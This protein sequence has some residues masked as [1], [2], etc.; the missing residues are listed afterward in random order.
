MGFPVPVGPTIS[1]AQRGCRPSSSTLR[2]ES[3]DNAPQLLIYL[4]LI[5]QYWHALRTSLSWRVRADRPASAF[6]YR[7]D[8]IFRR[9]P[10]PS[11]IPGVRLARLPPDFSGVRVLLKTRRGH[12]SSPS[13]LNLPPREFWRGADLLRYPRLFWG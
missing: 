8:G 10:E 3:P 13:P 9:E 5:W 4:M 11:G 6:R 1:V 12:F 2:L 7:I